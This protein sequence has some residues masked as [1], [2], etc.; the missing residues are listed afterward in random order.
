MMY[1]AQLHFMDPEDLLLQGP[2]QGEMFLPELPL[3]FAENSRVLQALA[4]HAVSYR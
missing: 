3:H 4:D 1:C 2:Q